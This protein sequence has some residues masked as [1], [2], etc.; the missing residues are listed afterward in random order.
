MRYLNPRPDDAELAAWYSEEYAAHRL[1][2]LPAPAAATNLDRAAREQRSLN[3]R[4]A[5]IA[6]LRMALMRRF[7]PLPWDGLR[8]LDVG[9]GNGAFLME[10]TR[11]HRVEGW[12]FD[13]T[14]AALAELAR[15]APNLRLVAGDLVRAELPARSFDVITLWHALEH[16]DDPVAVLSR[17]ATLLRPGGL[18][19]AEVPNATGLIARLCGRAWLG[20][21][22][23]R[24]MVHFGPRTLRAAARKAGLEEVCVLRRYTLNPICLSPLVAS[25][26]LWWQRRQGRTEVKVPAYRK[27][28]GVRGSVLH[29]VNGLERLLGGNGLLLAARAPAGE[30]ND[31]CR[32]TNDERITKTEARMP[33][34]TLRHSSLG[35]RASFVIRP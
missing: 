9:C 12:G 35:I 32:M 6:A 24:H 18:L 2:F 7:L 17:V 15:L 16:D 26:G 14:E 3:R 28:D 8:V 11:R 29:V 10:L 33:K 31:D 30:R 13:V 20:W 34:E 27:W 1:Q 22:L 25:L 23:P 21:D 5:R 19:L 4:F